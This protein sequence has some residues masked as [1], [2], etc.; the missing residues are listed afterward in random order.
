MLLKDQEKIYAAIDGRMA[1]D[2]DNTSQKDGA[3]LQEIL[4]R[5]AEP[6]Y[7]IKSAYSLYSYDKELQQICMK[8]YEGA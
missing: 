4:L 6:H 7:H 3:T 8:A 1:Y 5:L 2:L